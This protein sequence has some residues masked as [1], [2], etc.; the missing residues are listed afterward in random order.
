M[1]QKHTIKL[2][3]KKVGMTTVFDDAGAIIPCTVISMEPNVVSQIKTQETDGYQALQLAYS[4]VEG[5]NIKKIEAKVKKGPFGHFKK[6]NVEARK[7]VKESRVENVA[8]YSLGQELDV[9]FF[10]GSKFVDI[11]GRS[12]GKGYQGVMK[13]HG[14]SGG[15]G[16]HGS[17]FH[18][19]A[20][21]TGMRSTPGRCFPGSPRASR[22]GGET[23]TVQSLPIISINKEKNVIIVKGSVPGSHGSLIVLNKSIKKS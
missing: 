14:F 20:G 22:M 7:H 17:S 16:A 11:Q 6:A 13:K 10:E 2:M 5:K 1:K 19:H 8:E 9:T 12:K 3:G 21:S 15:P 4:K 23:K 18:R